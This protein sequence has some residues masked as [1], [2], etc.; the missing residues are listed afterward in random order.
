MIPNL[1]RSRLA[2]FVYGLVLGNA[3]MLL[4]FPFL[5]LPA[6]SEEPPLVAAPAAADAQRPLAFRF[7]EQAPGRDPLHWANG[8]GRFVRTAEGWVLRLEGDFRAGPGPDF[9]I[10]LNA[11]AVGE[12]RDFHADGLRLDAV[13]ALVDL[14][15]VHL[16]EELADHP[17][18]T[19][20]PVLARQVAEFRVRL[21][22]L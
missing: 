1:L 19:A 16:L 6:A 20:D 2:T 3:A 11:S 14:T 8:T 12:E 15:A 22:G 9:W 17:F 13:H 4:A 5:F 18:H 10:Y 21:L 7:D